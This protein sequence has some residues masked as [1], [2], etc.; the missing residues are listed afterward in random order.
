M[1]YVFKTWFDK[2]SP[3]DIYDMAE[4]K[5]STSSVLYLDFDEDLKEGEHNYQF[6][7][8]VGQFTPVKD[9]YGG[10]R[11]VVKREDKDGNVKFDYAPESKGYRW[12]ET[13]NVKDLEEIDRE[14]YINKVAEAEEVINSFGDFT[15]FIS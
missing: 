3:I 13:P 5:S 2:T 1:P 8:K 7:G 6:I 9:G 11:L 12:K 4:T 15:E 14:F 10:G